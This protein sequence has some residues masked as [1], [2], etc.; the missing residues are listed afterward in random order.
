LL[1]D[2]GNSINDNTQTYMVKYASPFYGVTGY[3]FQGENTAAKNGTQA[4]FDDTQKSYGICF[5]PPDV[6]A[7]VLVL[8]VEGN[9]SEGYWFACVQDR[10]ANHMIPGIAT[11]ENVD[12]SKE[13]KEKYNYKQGDFL[14]VAEINRL[15]NDET[16]GADIDKIKK[17]VHPIA[18]VFLQQGLLV[19]DVRGGATSTIRRNLPN[20]VFGISTP[21]PLDRRPGSKRI[22]LGKKQSRS[23]NNI[24]VS[25][26]GGTQM[27]FDD[28]D[29]QFQRKKPASEGGPEYADLLQKEKGTPNIPYGECFR[30]RTRTGHQ[31]LMHN[32]EDLIY[33]GNARGTTW[34]ELSSNGKIDIFAEDSISV[35][36][37]NDLNFKAGRDINIEAGRNVNIKATA[38]YQDPE[39]LYKE[40]GIFDAGNNEK[41]RVYIESVEN[42][43]LLIGRNGKI[44]VR[45]DEGTQGN[46]DVKVMGN[47]RVAVQDKD[48][49]PSFTNVSENKIL[50]EQPAG[51]PGLHIHSFQNTRITSGGKFEVKTTGNNNFT[52]GAD[53]NI[54]S[55]G[56]HVEKADKIHMNG[57]PTEAAESSEI[58]DK[59]LKLIVHPNPL[60]A[61]EAGWK[62]LYQEGTVDSIMKR[63]PMHEPWLLHENQLPEFLTPKFTD[64]EVE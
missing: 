9:A 13:D 62:N 6:G 46:L 27:V 59:V 14:P 48:T 64:R 31:I 24:P 60:T 2:D 20:M 16:T 21:G 41:G 37:Q 30:L 45:N 51:V 38:E 49:D 26:M 17:P 4:G 10:F 43:N 34:I 1:R 29:D 56:M 23:A 11:A 58:A 54:Q 61:V 7:T 32:S 63:V 25:R 42:F 47:M 50:A 18:D 55:T 39:N 5:V 57:P 3:D 22:S 12:I 28:G 33:I 15:A 44:Q 8:F 53:T 52:S 36:T 40:K 19:D 35:H